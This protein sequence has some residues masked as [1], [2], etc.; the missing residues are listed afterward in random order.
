MLWSGTEGQGKSASDAGVTSTKLEHL[1][2]E[3]IINCTCEVTE[4]DGLMIQVFLLNWRG[5]VTATSKYIFDSFRLKY[6]VVPIVLC[7]SV[8]NRL[9]FL[10]FI[11]I[12]TISFCSKVVQM[13]TGTFS[14]LRSS[15]FALYTVSA[16]FY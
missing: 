10:L 1:R 14:I 11:I 13:I 8:H 4:E 3:E 9:I 16:V 6:A 12:D 5:H 7:S 15:F 2:K